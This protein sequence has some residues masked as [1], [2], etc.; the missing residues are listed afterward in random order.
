MDSIETPAIADKGALRQHYGQ[1]SGLAE[2]KVLGFIDPHARAFIELS[3]FLVL[4]TAGPDG[5]TDA[6]PRGDA[7]G[8]VGILDERHL[9]IPDRIGN[10]RVDSYGNLVERPGV[11]LL[12]FVPGVDETLRVNGRARL[13]VEPELLARYA[14]QGKAP[15]AVVVVAVDEVFF[16]CGKALKR[17]RLWDPEVKIERSSFPTLGRII[18]DQT[19]GC[20]AEEADKR[21][22]NAYRNHLY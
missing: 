13:A 21:I 3:P 6:S 4:A 17:S 14:V 7:P 12:F 20:E 22:E 11:G 10:N 15:R 16:H 8:F 1:I 2:K 19:K 18:A 5:S 9:A